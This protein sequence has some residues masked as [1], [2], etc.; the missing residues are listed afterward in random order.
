MKSF[1]L[2]LVALL[3]LASL[4]FGQCAG[5]RGF[6][7]AYGAG[8]CGAAGF[9]LGGCGSATFGYQQQTFAA[10]VQ[11]YQSV[12]QFAAPMPCATAGFTYQQQAFAAPV[13]VYNT[14]FAVNAYST[15]FAAPFYGA[16]FVGRRGF[17]GVP[18]HH[19]GFGFGRR[20]FFGSPLGFNNGFFLGVGGR[21]G[22]RLAF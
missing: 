18:V 2:S 17:F 13:P 12:Q 4:G 19:H 8:T 14:G 10:P 15:G 11:S 7:A 6:G 20:G 21:R 9:G 1:S 5:R 3:L 16:G 22:F